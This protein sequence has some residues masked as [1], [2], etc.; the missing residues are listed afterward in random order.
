M[1]PIIG[2]IIAGTMTALVIGIGI[3]IWENVT[4]GGLVRALGGV[5]IKDLGQGACE[6][7]DVGEKA[8]HSGNIAKWCKPGEFITTLNLD[9][10]DSSRSC[11]VIGKVRCCEL[12]RR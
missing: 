4:D 5:S 7:R 6:W 9:A 1:K 2:Q 11:P 10:C 8:S 3:V 12:V